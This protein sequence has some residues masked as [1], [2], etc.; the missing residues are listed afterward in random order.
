VNITGK[1]GPWTC[2]EF[3]RNKKPGFAKSILPL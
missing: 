1:S 3:G 2:I